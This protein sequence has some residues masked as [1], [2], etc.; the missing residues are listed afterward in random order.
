M[1]TGLRRALSRLRFVA[2]R[3]RHDADAAAELEMHLA[4]LTEPTKLI[5]ASAVRL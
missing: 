1:W 3:T 2:A 4:M 5:N